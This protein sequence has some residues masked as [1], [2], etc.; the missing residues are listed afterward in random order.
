MCGW[1][2]AAVSPLDRP[3]ACRLADEG[4][5]VVV[6]EAVTDGEGHTLNKLR[7]IIA[8]SDSVGRLR[9]LVRLSLTVRHP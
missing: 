9:N 5:H 3:A 8:D 7:P 2:S 6:P 4:R 1:F